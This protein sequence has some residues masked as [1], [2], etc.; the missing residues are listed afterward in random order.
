MMRLILLGLFVCCLAMAVTGLTYRSKNMHF[1][2]IM[3]L[4]KKES[5][6]KLPKI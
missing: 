6:S 3:I 1:Y 5:L 4:Q 2:Y